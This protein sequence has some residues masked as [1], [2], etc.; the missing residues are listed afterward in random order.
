MAEDSPAAIDARS[1]FDV[2]AVDP[3]WSYGNKTEARTVRYETQLAA[4]QYAVVGAGGAG[5]VNRRTG[6]GIENIAALVPMDAIA[7]PDSA[8]FLWTTNPKMPFAFDLMAMWGFTYKTTL[9]WV[10][11]AKSR[12]VLRGGLGW[13]FRGATEHVLFGTRGR[14]GIPAN[15]RQP[16][17]IHAERSRHSAKPDEFYEMVEQVT[18]GQYRID[19]FA[20]RQRSGWWAWGDEVAPEPDRQLDLVTA[21]DNGSQEGQS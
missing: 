6:G 12:E 13:F 17:V 1:K 11:V 3:P 10:K 7:A 5:E 19:L 9:T 21:R 15:L 16:N 2:I 8:L 14:Y 4:Q 20:R 18:P